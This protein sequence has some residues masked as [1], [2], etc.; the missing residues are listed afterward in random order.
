MVVAG[1]MPPKRRQNINLPTTTQ[2][3]RAS[4]QTAGA[5]RQLARGVS[6]GRAFGPGSLPRGVAR[7]SVAAAIAFLVVRPRLAR[8]ARLLLGLLLRPLPAVKKRLVMMLLSA[9]AAPGAAHD[10]HKNPYDLSPYA[11]S[12]YAE[13]KA[14]VAK[15]RNNA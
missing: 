4:A 11:R 5:V 14:A 10:K 1:S 2:G 3:S 6:T 15:R 7:R 12:V 8:P 9:H 13:L